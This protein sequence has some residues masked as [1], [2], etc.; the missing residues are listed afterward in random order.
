MNNWNAYAGDYTT[1]FDKDKYKQ[2]IMKISINQP[3]SWRVLKFAP[4]MANKNAKLK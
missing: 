1:L 4:Q 2:V 3:G